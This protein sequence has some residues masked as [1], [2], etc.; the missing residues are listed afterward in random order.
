MLVA[1]AHLLSVPLS[2]AFLTSHRPRA[3]HFTS[4]FD[5]CSRWFDFCDISG[6]GLDESRLFI[7]QDD[8]MR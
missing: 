5:A 2:L 7:D 3:S 8:H 6:G 1:K 4:K